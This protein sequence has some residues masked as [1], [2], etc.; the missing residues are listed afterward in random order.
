MTIER[1]MFPPVDPTRRHLLS[2]AAGGAVAAA[3]ATKSVALPLDDS[4]LLKLEEQIFEQH[5]AASAFNDE[6][7]RLHRIWLDEAKRLNEEARQGR[8]TLTEDERWE[9]V[10]EMPECKECT[11]LESLQASF[12]KRMDELIKQMWQMPARTEEGRR[13]KAAVLLSCVMGSEWQ[14]VDKDTD[15]REGMARTLLIEF[16]GGEP[17]EMLR[18]QFASVQS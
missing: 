16:V 10:G 15:Y 18:D 11:R 9:L 6:I 1:P 3:V 4:E 13:A 2:I 17:G 8:C 12:D 14:E 7:W 5:K